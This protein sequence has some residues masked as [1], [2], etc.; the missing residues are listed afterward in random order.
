MAGGLALAALALPGVP[1]SAQP[2]PAATPVSWQL[3][4]VTA[5]PRTTQAW[6][7]GGTGFLTDGKAVVL[8]LRDGKWKLVKSG[9]PTGTSLAG[10]AAGSTTSIWA[11]G[12]V[13]KNPPVTTPLL[14]RSSGGSFRTVRLAGLGDGELSGVAAVSSHD[15]WAVG[16]TGQIEAAKPKLRPLALRWN[17]QKWQREP[18]LGGKTGY[19]VTAVSASSAS[20]AWLVAAT[21]SGNGTRLLH[22]N[23][24]KWSA[25]AFTPPAGLYVSGI[26]TTSRELAWITGTR[27]ISDGT[28]TSSYAARWNGSAWK[29]TATP[30]SHQYTLLSGVTAAGRTA[31]AA[32]ERLANTT[33]FQV[34]P[35][36]LRWNGRA[37]VAQHTPNPAGQP[38]GGQSGLDAISAASSSFAVTVGSYHADG[39]GCGPLAGEAAVYR[40]GTWHESR[41]PAPKSGPAAPHPACGG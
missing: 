28:V 32:G 41:L 40:H 36:I 6:A 12:F 13:Q 37:W 19:R 31:W 5:V 27:T 35:E 21:L 20:N 1:A 22:W 26:A 9:L 38:S 34:V 39:G 2:R 16:F 3:A 17:G 10:V 15:A 14:A 11:A 25:K 7:V 29:A 24:S 33:T 30:Q 18:V 8:H 4:A 23:G